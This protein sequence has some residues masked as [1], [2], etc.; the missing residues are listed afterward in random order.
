MFRYAARWLADRSSTPIIH[1][2]KKSARLC[3]EGLETRDVP[4]ATVYV[5]AQGGATDSTHFAT[6]TS[7]LPAAGAG[8][9]V[10]I[11]PGAA[12]DSGAVDITEAGVTITSDTGVSA[13]FTPLNSLTIDAN[14]VVLS[15]LNLATVTIDAG[16]GGTQILNST[17]NTITETTVT[18][19][20]QV[21]GNMIAFDRI[22]G[23]V[24]LT[25][26]PG[27]TGDVIQYNTFTGTEAEGTPGSASVMLTLTDDSNT[28]VLNNTFGTTGIFG[29]SG[30]L[31]QVSAG[32]GDTRGPAILAPAP[33]TAS[34]LSGIAIIGTTAGPLSGVVIQGNTITVNGQTM[35]EPGVSGA[36]ATG[37]YAISITTST[38]SAGVVVQDNS[39]TTGIGTGLI[40]SAGND[41]ATAV[42]VQGNDFNGNAIGVSYTGSGGT[43]IGSDLGGGPLGS[44]GNNVFASFTTAATSTS[45]AISVTGVGSGAV[46]SATGNIFG[47]A[48]PS[49]VVN[50]A[51]N[52]NVS[53]PLTGDLGFVQTLYIELLGRTGSMTELQGWVN[54]LNNGMS[55]AQ[56]TTSILNST[57]SLNRI[58]NSIYVE[59]L[60]RT[61][62]TAELTPWSTDIQNGMSLEQVIADIVSSPEWQQKNAGSPI[63]MYYETLLHRTAGA[64]EIAYWQGVF[65][66]SGLPTVAFGIVSSTEFRT[67]Y[68][69]NVLGQVLHN[70]QDSSQVQS[71][72][73]NTSLN[74]LQIEADLIDSA[75]FPSV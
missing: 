26:S 72:A 6:L 57:E 27:S 45:A 69:L 55:Q 46:L 39:I 70:P 28:S 25:G 3:L 68:L 37:S 36:A 9:T 56:V 30:A 19:T 44:S 20:T 16:F 1:L 63:E 12:P 71:L 48:T 38:L 31:G 13:Y 62:S 29:T 66:T 22:L 15:H 33:G 50:G 49:T 59:T 23:S 43:T 60:G 51:S 54:N 61:G 74:L 52:V 34:E 42:E 41:Q 2:E 53:S 4:Q 5:V 75:S 73:S 32:P 8:G 65:D 24:N 10:I 7:A 35:A 21:G 11:E 47:T 40:I 17:V 14:G 18:G 64:N 67:D 58:V